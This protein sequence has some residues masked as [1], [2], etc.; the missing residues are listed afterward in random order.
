M[1]VMVLGAG[2]VGGAMVRDLAGEFDVAVADLSEASLAALADV[3]GVRRVRADLADPTEVR[4]VVADA[5]IVVGAV[6]G[7]MGYAT[8]RA[9]LEAGRDIVDISFFPEDCFGLDGLA[10]ERGRT[11]L[12]DFGVAPGCDNLILG[13]LTERMERVERF[14][15]LVGGLP[16]V[17]VWPWE[18]KAG[19]SP[20]DVIAE[21]TRPARYRRAGTV[22]TMPALSEPELIDVPG[23]GTLEAF[24]TDG[25][26]SLLATCDAPEMVEK[27]LRY[28][29]HIEKVRVLRE[30]GLFSPE[31]IDAGG[32]RVRPIDVAAR[33]LFPAWQLAPGEED[34]TVLR[35][36]VEGVE[37]GRRACRTYDMLDRYDRATGITSMARTTGYTCTAGVRLLAARRFRRPGVAP[38]ELVGREAGC[39]EFVREQL[40]ARGIVFRESVEPL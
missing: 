11:A 2:R 20:I 9:V 4:R 29:G 1:R 25:L 32:V 3:T 15:C 27:T 6:P 40:A 24:N 12:V 28:P 33:L 7:D 16:A 14:V 5:D 26:R 13:H 34:L 8:V 35:V 10:R 23:V 38:P 17:R 36:T 39:W 22:V 30:M 37:G 21:Y 18:Y 31:A 19:F